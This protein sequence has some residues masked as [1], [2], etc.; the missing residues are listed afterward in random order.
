M[1]LYAIGPSLY[2]LREIEARVH[3]GRLNGRK[4]QKWADAATRH[5]VADGTV[6]G[7]RAGALPDTSVK[8]G[9]RAALLDML[10]PRQSPSLLQLL[11]NILPVLSQ[12]IETGAALQ[13]C[14]G[15]AQLIALLPG[16]DPDGAVGRPAA[17]SAS[18]TAG[19]GGHP[20]ES[21]VHCGPVDGLSSGHEMRPSGDLAVGYM[22]AGLAGA[23]GNSAAAQGAGA[24]EDLAGGELYF[25][26]SSNIIF[27]Y[28]V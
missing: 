22:L 27:I 12:P 6:A 13:I 18:G 3:A 8:G 9:A 19:I 16:T 1:G 14:A 10:L 17:I 15:A 25:M 28:N 23:L 11:L 5:T 20:V 7:K 2:N 24:A 26:I 4:S 21:L